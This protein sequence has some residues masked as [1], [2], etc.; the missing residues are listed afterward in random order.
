MRA[1]IEQAPKWTLAFVLLL[2]L[3]DVERVDLASSPME[4]DWVSCVF[5]LWS[6][7]RDGSTDTESGARVNSG[8][9]NGYLDEDNND[10][11]LFADCK[12]SWPVTLDELAS[13]EFGATVSAIR[14]LKPH[15]VK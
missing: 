6:S 2:Y 1:P 10:G 5:S 13:G 3:F 8:L 14:I 9:A 11:S 7:S 12:S 4:G 15:G